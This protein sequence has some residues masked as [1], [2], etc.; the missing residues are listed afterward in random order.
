MA[1]LYPISKFFIFSQVANISYRSLSSLSACW[2]FGFGGEI[3]LDTEMKEL[4]RT[5]PLNTHNR[6]SLI[7]T[8][9][10]CLRHL[11]EGRSLYGETLSVHT[12]THTHTHT[13]M[14]SVISYL[15]QIPSREKSKFI[16]F[17]IVDLYPS[18][19]H[20]LKLLTRALLR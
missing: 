4:G 20:R 1:N 3:F 11:G 13:H 14:S 17:D 15:K 5:I 18:I 2:S 8:P 12:H 9:Y 19:H 6:R 16:K 10:V 7:C